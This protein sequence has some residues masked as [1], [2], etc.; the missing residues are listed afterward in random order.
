MRILAVCLLSLGIASACFANDGAVIGAGGRVRRLKG[1]HATVRMVR[2][3]VRIDV[4]HS[5]YDVEATFIFCNEGARATVAMGFPESGGGDIRAQEY[6]SRSAF[7][8]FATWVD[9]QRVNARRQQAAINEGYRAYWVK[10]VTFGEKQERTVRVRSR[11][12]AGG[13][14]SGQ[15]SVTYNFTGGNWRGV[16]DESVLRIVTHLPGVC[17]VAFDTG[18]SKR[19]GKVALDSRPRRKGS[20]FVLRRTNWEAE[21]VG[22]LLYRR[23]L[24]GWLFI[25]GIQDYRDPSPNWDVVVQPGRAREL[26]WAPPGLMRDAVVFIR[27]DSLRDYLDSRSKAGVPGAT[28]AI[29]WDQAARQVVLQVGARHWEFQAGRAVML[30]DGKRS[31]P[32]PAPPFISPP[33]G[34]HQGGAFYVPLKPV[35]ELF[36]M[37]FRVSPSGH[38]LYIMPKAQAGIKA[39]SEQS[40]TPPKH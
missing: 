20:E 4:Y 24:P 9:G 33:D 7:L 11:S 32:L 40:T 30:V 37:T 2:E 28:S 23:T 36:G 16:V 18:R 10:Q 19:K 15:R 1:E 17:L 29:S 5:H 6:K 26:N 14:I 38:R 21:G 13:D 31:V 12:T 35:L 27:L 22:R 25:D 34:Y 3:Q 39:G 8:R